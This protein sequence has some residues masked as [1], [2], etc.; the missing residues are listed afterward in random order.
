MLKRIIHFVQYHNFFTIAVMFVFLG[1]SATLAANPEA[2]IQKTEMVRSV[3]NTFVVNTDFD[4]YDMGLKINTVIEDADRYYVE[5]TYLTV[6]VENYVWK[7][8]PT[9]GLI[10]VSKKELAGK[11][12]GVY[13]ADQLGQMVTQQIAFLKEFQQREKKIG[14]TPKVVA[15]E[16]SGLVGRFLGPEEKSFEGYTPVKTPPPAEEKTAS[17]VE[18]AAAATA[19]RSG[20]S[21]VS[22][23]APPSPS[24]KLVTQ[25]E[26]QALIQSA[27]QQLLANQNAS[28]E[29][30]AVDTGAVDD[31]T[32]PVITLTGDS[33]MYLSVGASFT[34]PGITVTDDSAGTTSRRYF[35]NGTEVE[36]V[37]ID[38]S[39]AG[40]HIITYKAI[41]AQG[42]ESTATRSVIVGETAPEQPEPEAPPVEAG[43]TTPPVAETPQTS[44][45]VETATTTPDTPPA[46]EPSSS[47]TATTTPEAS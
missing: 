4:V 36:E 6:E 24:E 28:S 47:E 9:N 21:T 22:Y 25:S 46:P 35:V 34:D 27:V 13:V 33:P 10:K 14:A 8:I 7:P 20:V 37:A 45:P 26:V 38:T 30:V 5:Y 19:P 43:T 1:A 32:P 39:A 2:V 11:D 12:L 15:V 18:I 3:D 44:P 16:Y 40:N 17:P 23:G 31:T 29:P 41:D 42:N